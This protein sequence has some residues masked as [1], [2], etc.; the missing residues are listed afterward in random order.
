VARHRHGPSLTAIAGRAI[1]RNLLFER[2]RSASGV[3]PQLPDGKRQVICGNKRH[4]T[5]A[6]ADAARTAGAASVKT[7]DP[8]TRKI[9]A[10]P[11]CAST[12]E[13]ITGRVF[14]WTCSSRLLTAVVARSPV[15]G[16]R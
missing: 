3:R 13:K 5:V 16:E 9:I 14:V 8:K 7:Q 12:P 6:L 1:A 11:P 10:R 2:Q 4:D 15:F